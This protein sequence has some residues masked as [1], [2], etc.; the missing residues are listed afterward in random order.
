[1]DTLHFD[2][3][4][5]GLLC[6]IFAIYERKLKS[7]KIIEENFLISPFD[8]IIPVHTERTKA[9]R[10]WQ[11]L[12]KHLSPEKLASFYYCFLSEE[13]NSP[14]LLTEFAC[15]VFD[16][17]GK[18]VETNYGKEQVLKLSQ[19]S[20]K[21]ARERHRFEAFVRFKKTADELYF[22]SIEPDFNILP[23]LISHFK[24]RYADQK[25][26]IYDL[27]RKYGIYYNL[28]DVEF[29][30]MDLKELKNRLNS[31]EK[32]DKSENDFQELWQIYFKNTNIESRKNTKLHTQHVPK[33]YW[34]YLTEKQAE[35]KNL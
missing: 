2:G 15:Y 26:A 30:E 22:S 35:I 8:T 16:N 1:M 33:R 9:E 24:S 25:W 4:F 18:E 28:Q 3:S 27:K 31:V 17:P 20:R 10:V 34:K 14:Q 21:V 5:E 32:M 23:L 13:N 7:Y 11:G 19:I 12:K 29:I 6:C